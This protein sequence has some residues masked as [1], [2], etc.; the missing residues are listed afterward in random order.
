[1]WTEV[2]PPNLAGFLV[3]AVSFMSRIQREREVGKIPQRM[4]PSV[5][6]ELG[7]L[8]RVVLW[9]EPGCEAILGQLLPE[10]KS[11]FFKRYDVPEA[12]REFARMAELISENGAEIVRMKDIF[13]ATLEDYGSKRLPNSLSALT[14][15]II[16]RGEKFYEKYGVGDP[17]VLRLVERML[18]EDAEQYGERGAIRLNWTLSLSKKVPMANIF[19]T[20]DQSNVLGGKIVMSRMAR[21]IRKPEVGIYRK[22]YE[23][24]GYGRELVILKSGVFEGGDAIIFDEVCFIG[25]GVRTSRKAVKEIYKQIGGDLEKRGI[26]QIAAVVNPEHVRLRREDPNK[27]MDVMH[28]DTFWTPIDEKTVLACTDEVGKRHV[29]V[30]ERKGGKVILRNIGSF[31]DFLRTRGY[32]VLDVTKEEQINYATNLLNLGNNKIVVPLSENS[33]VIAEIEKNGTKVIA[34]EIKEL[35]GGYGAVHCMTAALVR[36]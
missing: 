27:A 31:A 35:V 12:R 6:S 3:I 14:S 7:L 16:E 1:M 32:R 19:Y 20:R 8:K 5:N 23:A 11:L 26:N 29:E 2:N 9:G 21:S 34:A 13:V 36:E 4:E 25:V 17:S 10:E 24:L 30:V 18:G 22:A 33:R 15:Q 28:L